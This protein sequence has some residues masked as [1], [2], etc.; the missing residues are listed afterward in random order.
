MRLSC[1]LQTYDIPNLEILNH[2]KYIPPN[3]YFTALVPE[4]AGYLQF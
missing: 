3:F 1:V 2:I 4:P